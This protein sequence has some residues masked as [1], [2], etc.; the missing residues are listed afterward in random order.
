MKEMYQ[1]LCT[2]DPIVYWYNLLCHNPATPRDFITLWLAC[3]GRRVTKARLKKFGMIDNAE[4]CFCQEEETQN[5]LL[6]GCEELGRIWS[7]VLD[8]MQI[9]RKPKDWKEELQWILLAA[10]GKSKQAML[11][12]LVVTETVYG[13]W[14]YRNDICY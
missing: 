11:F 10:R 7:T 2:D 1:K 13:V 4:C 14:K 8:W 3:H 6:F 12:K 9:K 5:H